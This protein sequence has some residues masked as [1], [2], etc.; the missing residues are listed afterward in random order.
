MHTR[1]DCV[2]IIQQPNQLFQK[3]LIT[4]FQTHFGLERKKRGHVSLIGTYVENE[5]Y[6]FMDSVTVLKTLRGRSILKFSCDITTHHLKIFERSELLS[7]FG[8]KI[9]GRKEQIGPFC[10]CPHVPSTLRLLLK[11]VHA[12]YCDCTKI[13]KGSY[14]YAHMLCL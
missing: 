6:I 12:W 14:P 8:K 2:S 3:Q 11:V 4:E 9:I 10:L 13:F 7:L 1:C 5:K